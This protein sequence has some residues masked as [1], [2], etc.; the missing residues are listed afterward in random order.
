VNDELL[1]HQPEP[2][3]HRPVLVAAFTGW[4]DI[5]GGAT[6]AVR[7]LGGDDGPLLAAIDADGFFDFTAR[8]PTVALDDHGRRVVSWPRNEL[9]AASSGRSTSTGT[10]GSHDLVLLVGEEPNIRWGTFADLLV[11]AARRLRC[12]MV[13]TVGTVAD[14]QP[15][16]RAPLVFGSSTNEALASRLGLSRPRYEGPTGVVGVL[17]DRLDRAGLPA[18]A[19]RAPVPHYLAASPNPKSTVALL[20]HLEHVLGVPTR[21]GALAREVEEWDRRHDAAVAS[22]DEA[23][24]Y[25]RQLEIVHDRRLEAAAADGDD[26]AAELEAFLREQR[27]TGDDADGGGGGGIGGGEA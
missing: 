19:L 8:R 3:L 23:P 20:Q 25:V 4:F 16:T 11:E 14:T 26:L 9:R 5:A 18:I 12:E 2:G 24:A 22:D 1:W 10:V 21:H 13:V 6:S 7:H 17:H 27:G 15:H